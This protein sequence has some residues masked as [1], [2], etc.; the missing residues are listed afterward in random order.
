M[1]N[2]TKGIMDFKGLEKTI[3]IELCRVACQMMANYL[4]IWDQIILSRR[5]TDEYRYV[6]KR[7]TSIKTTMGTVS[8]ERTYYKRRSGGYAFLLDEAMGI[9]DGCGRIS[10][11]LMEQIL[12]ECSDKSF[13]KAADSI[14][15]L[16]GQ[17]ISRMGA[18]NVV[19]GYGERVKKQEERLKELDDEGVVG[20]LGN[21]F[22]PVLFS[23]FDDVWLNRQRETRRKAGAPAEK[24]RAR[25]GRKP[26]HIGTAYTGWE[27]AKDGSFT[28]V[29]KFAYAAF[30]DSAEF[31]ST[32]EALL[33]QRFDMDGIE[34]LIINGD[35]EAWIRRIAENNDAI[36]QLDPFHRS[37]AIMR[38]VKDKDDRKRVNDTMKEKDV[39]KTLDVIC[40]MIAT[41]SEEQKLKKLETLLTY[42]ASNKDILLPW[43]ERGI[44]IPEP[45]EGIVYRNLGLQEHNNCDMI[46]QRMKNRKGSW[47]AGGANNMAKILCLRSTLG[48]DAMLGALPEPMGSQVTR[49]PLSAA[50]APQYDGRGYDAA[51]LYA[52]MPFEE[53]F[54]TAGRNAIRG[55][56]RQ[57]PISSL[58]LI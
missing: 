6:D 38:A 34:R 4:Q 9:A 13:R 33:R 16:T 29:E 3:F 35:G 42:F 30:S 10:E 45:P 15:S 54:V 11:N 51:W 37:Q 50:K 31:I 25:T 48:L 12:V 24:G 27:Q 44:R 52:G 36:L 47:S 53:T 43:Q 22:C 19:Q 23:E 7:Q 20:Q 32:F 21:V 55:M 56:L 39:E 57:K 2:I 58:S 17:E 18:W 46:T 28:T 14:S 49:A 41:N 5:D 8:Y 26:M 40:N 1:E